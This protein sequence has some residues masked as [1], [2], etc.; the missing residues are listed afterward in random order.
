M[1]YLSP[2]SE[3]NANEREQISKA[4]AGMATKNV[5]FI[6]TLFD[7]CLD[8]L[9]GGANPETIAKEL[10][11]LSIGVTARVVNKCSMA[12]VSFFCNLT[13][14]EREDIATMFYASKRMILI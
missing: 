2:E 1:Y 3:I 4:L 7:A 10:N 12:P 11:K 5:R 9:D 6:Q 13:G 8:E 14:N